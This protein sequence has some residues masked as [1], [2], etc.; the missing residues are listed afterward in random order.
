MAAAPP[1]I[2]ALPILGLADTLREAG[3]EVVEWRRGRNDDEV[4]EV[5]GRIEVLVTVGS[6]AL[7]DAPMDAARRLGLILCL[8]AGYERFDPAGLAARGVR[9]AN[10]GGL[11]AADVA[12][13]AIGLVIASHRRIIDGDHWVRQG[14]W[15]RQ[16]VLTRRVGG[17]RLG[18]VGLGAIGDAVARRAQAMD[19]SIC[20]SGPNPK[21]APWP[22]VASSL[23][24]AEWADVLVI[25]SRA[26]EANRALI[27][28]ATLDALG[29]QG[30]LVNISRG[31]LVDEDALIGALKEGRLGAAAL[32]VFAEEPTDPARWRE[33]PNLILQP[34]H[35]GSTY[36]SIDEAKAL[37]VENIRRFT[38]GRQLISALN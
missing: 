37:V 11:N 28:R 23:A 13:L 8:G 9:L 14:A 35:G 10:C 32:D 33:V 29:P 34:H 7:P 26:T 12:D 16:N 24:L 31:S 5:A 30:L 18:I 36:E 15:P 3:F 25:C 2:L 38:S 27:D 19:M 4:L 17:R 6:R 1:V 22:R 20:W 21:Q